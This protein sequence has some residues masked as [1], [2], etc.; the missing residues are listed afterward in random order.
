MKRNSFVSILLVLCMLLIG[1]IGLFAAGQSEDGGSGD[2]KVPSLE[3]WWAASNN[4]PAETMEDPNPY[5]ERAIDAIGIGWDRPTVSWNSGADYAEKLKLRLAA[6]DPPDIMRLP[7]VG[8]SVPEMIEG[9]VAADLT[10][11]LPK[12]A[13]TV[14]AAVPED[15]WKVVK[16]ESP[17]KDKIFFIPTLRNAPTHGAFIRKDWLDRVGLD[18]PKTETDFFNVLKAFKE[19]DANGNGDASDEIPTSGRGPGRWWDHLFTPFGVAMVEGFPTWDYYDGEVQYGGVQPEMKVALAALSKAYKEG[20]IDPEVL[21]NKPATWEGKIFNDQVGI[22]FH[23]PIFL[24]SKISK[25]YPNFPKAEWIWLPPYAVSG[26]DS[27]WSE[28]YV[29]SM[30]TNEKVVIASNDEE[31]IINALKLLEYLQQPKVASANV[32]GIEGIHY[33]I[34][35]GEMVRLPATEESEAL[36]TWVTDTVVRTTE[37]FKTGSILSVL[38]METEELQKRGLDT[39]EKLYEDAKIITVVG[40]NL[41]TSIYDGFPDIAT[42]QLY[43]STMAKIIIGEESIDAFD[44]YVERWYATGG[45]EVTANAQEAAAELGL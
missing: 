20:L 28:G 16:Y 9:G 24:G 22:H 41:P 3:V 14:Y 40:T 15:V 11:L 7:S 39:L 26:V 1:S 43:F 32:N 12:Y 5:Q 30:N 18:L 19:Q 44:D 45:T 25:V 8:F 4:K 42:H 10:A 29:S 6:G 34:V 37:V 38:G 35:D 2:G 21:I 23:M 27:K 33:E 13:P 17:N 31:T 36:E